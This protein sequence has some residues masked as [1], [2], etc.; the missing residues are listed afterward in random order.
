MLMRICRWH[1]CNKLVSHEEVYCDKHKQMYIEYKHKQHKARDN[2]IRHDKDEYK[3][4]KFYKSIP[5]IR[6]RLSVIRRCMYMDILELYNTGRIVE[7]YTVHHIIELRDD[8]TKRLDID[9]LIYL[10]E[11]NHRKVH[12]LYDKDKETKLKTQRMLIEI[13]KKFKT[14]YSIQS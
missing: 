3:L 10:T 2:M 1:G 8:W 7:G 6:C 5:W 11:S 4:K 14:D 9:N 13:I 12:T